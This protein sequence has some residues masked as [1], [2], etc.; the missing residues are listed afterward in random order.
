VNF[1]KKLKQ[2]IDSKIPEYQY[3][4]YPFLIQFIYGFIDFVDSECGIDA[5]NLTDNLDPDKIF[6]KFLD[7]YFSQYCQD[8]IDTNRYQLTD[9]NKRLFL[10][11]IRFLNDNKGKKFSFDIALKYLT[12]FFVNNDETY[13]ESIDYEIIEDQNNWISTTLESPRPEI[14]VPYRKPYTYIIRGDFIRDYVLSLIE[15]LNPVGFYPEF[16]FT[17]YATEEYSIFSNVSEDSEISVGPLAIETYYIS[18]AVSETDERDYLFAPRPI[19]ELDVAPV[20]FL[21][22]GKHSFDGTRKYDGRDTGIFENFEILTYDSAVLVD[23]F[24]DQDY[25]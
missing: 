20:L 24:E 19:E 21:Y 4:R 9:E 1:T 12:R 25:P 10:S 6:P 3:K 16:Q 18:D 15:T 14:V 22:D 7:S 23:T 13:F 17:Q 2:I 5:L 8:L 11:I